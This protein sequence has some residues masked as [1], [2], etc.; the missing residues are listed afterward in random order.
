[1]VCLSAYINVAQA[2]H[3][4]IY[5]DSLSAAYGLQL[6]QGW[7]SLLADDLSADHRVSNA[8]ISGETSIGGLARL[9]ETLK[10][11]NP[12]IVFIELGANDGL[13][14]YPINKIKENIGTMIDLVKASNAQAVLAGISI[15]A[16]YG[17]RY[18]DQFRS[19]YRQLAE[20][21]EVPFINLYLEEFVTTPGLIQADGLHPTAIGQPL[22]RDS[23]IS[24]FS[25]FKILE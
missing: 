11:L 20:E 24:F 6:D 18:V 3:L 7:V 17:P 9:P 21:R 13:R 23:V 16:S 19:L 4:M 25:Q 1:M 14:G 22:I 15:P 5:G 10:E 2:K 12:D 8:S